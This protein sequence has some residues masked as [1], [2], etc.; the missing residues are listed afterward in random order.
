[1]RI[2]ENEGK[3][4]AYIILIF[5]LIFAYFGFYVLTIIL[6]FILL[7]W[8]FFYSSRLVN[9]TMPNAIVSPIN[10]VINSI[11]QKEH[12]VEFII[13]SRFN[14]RIYAPSDLHEIQVKKYHGFYFLYK[15]ELSNKIGTKELMYAETILNDE[16]LFV[17]I[18]VLPRAFS[19]CGLCISRSESLFLEKIG[20][21]NMGLLRISIKG[22]NITIIAKENEKVIG[23]ISPLI[24]IKNL[25]I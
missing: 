24:E 17:E 23:G 21:L 22:N 4:G 19:V 13:K 11:N 25:S 7:T 20:F 2:L 16:K 6:L 5:G 10:G 3:Q 8:L 9:P 1:M 18:E 15:S 12:S 14:G